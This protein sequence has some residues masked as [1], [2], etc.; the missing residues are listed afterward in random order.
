MRTYQ[1][2]KEKFI[3]L[4]TSQN[5]SKRTLLWFSKR[6]NSKR[7]SVINPSA[8]LFSFDSYFIYGNYNV[9]AN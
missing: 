7:Q 2:I 9:P 3:S 8:I 4:H 5:V 1:C 6:D